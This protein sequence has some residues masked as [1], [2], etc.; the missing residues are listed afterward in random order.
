MKLFDDRKQEAKVWKIRE[1]GLGATAHVPAEPDA[2]PGWEDSAV[3][4]RRSAPTSAAPRSLFERYGY[5]A[6]STATSARAASIRASTSTC[7]PRPGHA[8]VP[9]VPR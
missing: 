6:R 5:D 7:N 8:Q 3:P 2:W 9:P 4:R 1:S